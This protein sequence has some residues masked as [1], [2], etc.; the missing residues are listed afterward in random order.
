MGQG[1]GSVWFNPKAIPYIVS[2]KMVQ[3]RYHVVY[4]CKEGN[5]FIVTKPNGNTFNFV[6]SKAGLHYLDT[7]KR[8]VCQS[9]GDNGFTIN[10]VVENKVKHTKNDYSKA[11][12]AQELQITMGHPSTLEFKNLLDRNEL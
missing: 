7:S 8:N 6:Q 12:R 1:Y 9:S 4:N 5:G 11:F 3:S 2:L 10:A